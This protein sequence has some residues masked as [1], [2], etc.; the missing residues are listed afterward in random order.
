MTK[1]E[2]ES[3]GYLEGQLLIAMPSLTD[4]WFARSLVY[5]C[6]HTPDGA[7]GLIVNQRAPE[8]S[9]ADLLEQLDIDGIDED[10]ELDAALHGMHVNIGGPVEKGRGFVL[11]SSDYVLDDSTLKISEDFCLTAT[12][13]IPA[14]NRRRGGPRAGHIG[15][16]V[17]G[18]GCWT[19]GARD[20]GQWLA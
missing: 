1:H 5:M 6:S 16:W 19:I 7:M 4:K 17:C 3:E 12:V 13:D 8:I 15:A 2:R 9:F 18:L 11:H 20:P 10:Y 14:L